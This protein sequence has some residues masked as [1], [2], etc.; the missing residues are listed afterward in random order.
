MADPDDHEI[1]LL[2]AAAI[3]MRGTDLDHSGGGGDFTLDGLQDDHSW[4]AVA[5][6]LLW[7]GWATPIVTTATLRNM[8]EDLSKLDGQPFG[9]IRPNG[10]LVVYGEQSEDNY[11]ITPNERSEYA[12]HALGWCFLA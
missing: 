8:L 2:R 7:N 1:E 6:G 11:V 9:E 12:L 5:F 3:Q 10:E 4:H